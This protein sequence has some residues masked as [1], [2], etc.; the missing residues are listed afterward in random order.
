MIVQSDF[1]DTIITCNMGVL[2]R[3]AFGPEERHAIDR[4]YE[5]GLVSVEQGNKR[6]FSLI[7]ES[8][9]AIEAFVRKHTEARPG[10]TAFLND[11][12]RRDVRFSIVSSG[13]DFYIRIALAVLGVPDLE[14]FSGE[15]TFG[16]DGIG[17]DYHDP[18]GKLIDRGFKRSC[19]DHFK[20]SGQPVIYIGDGRS[21]LEA[22]SQA[23]HVFAIGR[24]QRLLE[25]RGIPHHP[26]RDFH[27]ISRGLSRILG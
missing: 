7:K 21:D 18:S 6:Q 12:R 8:R 10:F 4:D 1:D 26:F 20:G 11:C 5:A 15:A 16:K 3:D 14:F 23:D 25:E 9:P 2:I 27:D 22:A 19:L 17:V 13:L 24:L